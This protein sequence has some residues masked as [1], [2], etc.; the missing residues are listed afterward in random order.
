MKPSNT[1]G[2]FIYACHI[3]SSFE[4]IKWSYA[5]HA[6]EFPCTKSYFIVE[7]RGCDVTI[8]EIIGDRNSG[9]GEFGNSWKLG[10][11]DKLEF[12]YNGKD[13]AM[14]SSLDEYI[15]K[16]SLPPIKVIKN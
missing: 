7:K 12:I 1:I 2:Y 8:K 11:E 6:I 14:L 13:D 4:K 16:I 15:K 9:L 10:F 5:S 3:I